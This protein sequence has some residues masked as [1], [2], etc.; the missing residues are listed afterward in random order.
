MARAAPTH[1]DVSPPE[2]EGVAVLRTAPLCGFLHV[3][4]E[5][6]R[7]PSSAALPRSLRLV[8]RRPPGLEEIEVTL[9]LDG[10]E[11]R[12]GF[13]FRPY[14]FATVRRRIRERVREEEAR[15]ISGL[16]EILLRDSAC[17]DRLV[18]SIV[19][20][21]TTLF[22]SPSFYRSF[23]RHVM[24]RLRESPRRRLWL[25]GCATGE[26]LYSIAVL[27]QE[28]ELGDHLQIYATE[29][30]EAP[31]RQAERGAFSLARLR[32]AELSYRAAGGRDHL[33]D[34]YRVEGEEGVFRTELR[35]NVV[36]ASHNLSTDASFNEFD[37][38]LCRGVLPHLGPLLEA[39]AHRL[40]YES[41]A[42]AGFLGLGRGVDLR[43]G[44]FEPR[45]A[46]VDALN[47]IFRK[48]E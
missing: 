21:V 7:P 14:D 27:L 33:A 4:T 32:A 40:M 18:T 26:E 8:P 24:P 28:A 20:N 42:R 17:F 2:G 1:S 41:L 43:R 39:R 46:I 12:Y 3:M 36:F 22:S 37:V 9:L 11:R 30:H 10:I 16:Q 45:Y 19:V 23:H 48:Q 44:P 5:P 29:M 13:D 31:L 15:T 35:R 47:G 6:P 25:V 38:I 34:H